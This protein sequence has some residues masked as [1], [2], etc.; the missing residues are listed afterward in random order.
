MTSETQ[1]PT[2][3][4]MIVIY[5]KK[6]NHSVS[7]LPVPINEPGEKALGN[8]IVKRDVL[9]CR[10]Y[11]KEETSVAPCAQSETDIPLSQVQSHNSHRPRFDKEG[12]SADLEAVGKQLAALKEHFKEVINLWNAQH[13]EEFIAV[14]IQV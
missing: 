10:E 4:P 14:A 9:K 2:G 7:L 6:G 5:L 12:G 11:K 3:V 8:L 13:P 1:Q